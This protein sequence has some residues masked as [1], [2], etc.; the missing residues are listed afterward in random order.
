MEK[1]TVLF[2]ILTLPTVIAITGFISS[3]VLAQRVRSKI[4]S[5]HR[6]A[7]RSVVQKKLGKIQE[8][9]AR[10]ERM[11]ASKSARKRIDDLRVLVKEIRLDVKELALDAKPMLPAYECCPCRTG[12][13]ETDTQE[14]EK[15][16]VNVNLH[17]SGP[18]RERLQTDTGLEG[19]VVEEGTAGSDEEPSLEPMSNESFA[20][21]VKEIKKQSFGDDKL[22]I[23][24]QAAGTNY[25][26]VDQVKKMLALFSFPDDKLEALK[27]LKERIIDTDNLFKIYS[28]FVHSS[29]KEAARR[30][31]EGQ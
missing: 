10:V 1:N 26:V 16:Q 8:K 31:L 24:R 7:R 27:L 6:P 20:A 23:L 5:T 19:T 2:R 18:N 3:P 9:L 4:H 30:I 12:R 14:Q 11:L 22:T 13:G 28:S 21:L 25:F 17:V 29:D 15:V